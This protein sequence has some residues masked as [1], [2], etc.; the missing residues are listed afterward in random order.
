MDSFH[1]GL[2][3]NGS[4]ANLSLNNSV[5]TPHRGAGCAG[6]GNIKAALGTSLS[7]TTPGRSAKTP[8]NPSKSV[9]S[10]LNKSGGAGGNRRTPSAGGDR[11][12]PGRYNFE[13]AGYLLTQ[14]DMVKEKVPSSQP[15]SN[16]SIAAA[17]DSNNQQPSTEFELEVPARKLESSYSKSLTESLLGV[18]DLTQTRILSFAQKPSCPPE[19]YQNAL[20]VIYQG[21]ASSS[22]SSNPS[23]KY[24]VLPKT[25]ERVLDA[26]D[27]VDDFYLNLLDWSKS[28][29]V[30]IALGDQVYLWTA[31]TA[32]ITKIPCDKHDA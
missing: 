3:L 32:E 16:N 13:M 9:G 6:G 14:T 28:N 26:P 20:K 18:T 11:F 29:V 15:N 22:H 31:H 19:G 25:P 10:K 27:V 30:G 12:M 4:L 8:T 1:Q 17:G 7:N 24:R 21:S 23:T 5:K 2:S